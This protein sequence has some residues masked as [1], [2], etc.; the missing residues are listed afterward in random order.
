MN[1]CSGPKNSIN[2][3]IAYFQNKATYAHVEEVNLT[4]LKFVMEL[5]L[6]EAQSIAVRFSRGNLLTTTVFQT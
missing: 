6:S 5:L 1:Y 4:L 3:Q 2:D